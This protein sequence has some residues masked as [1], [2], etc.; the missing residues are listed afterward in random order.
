M[1]NIRSHKTCKPSL[2]EYSQGLFDGATIPCL[3]APGASRAGTQGV[4]HG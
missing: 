4:A 2:I 3:A 1:I